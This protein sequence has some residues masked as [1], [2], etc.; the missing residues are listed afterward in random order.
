MVIALVRVPARLRGERVV[1]EFAIPLVRVVARMCWSRAGSEPN[2]RSHVKH[3]K[4][5][6]RWPVA[7]QCLSRACQPAGNFL[8]QV[9]HS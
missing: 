2:Q 3:S 5:G 7:W 1:T 9:P 8:A 4:R 6:A